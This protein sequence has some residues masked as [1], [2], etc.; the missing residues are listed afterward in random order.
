[1]A[2]SVMQSDAAA[3]IRPGRPSR[4]LALMPLWLLVI[5]AAFSPAFLQALDAKPP[6]IL[7][8]PLATVVDVAALVWMAVGLVV[9]WSAR[10]RVVESIAL[11]VFTIP[12]TVVVV[13]TPVVIAVAQSLG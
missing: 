5:V 12:A 7:G 3:S 6:D 13:L 2:T 9:I 4:I 11:T 10:S 8:V 1:M